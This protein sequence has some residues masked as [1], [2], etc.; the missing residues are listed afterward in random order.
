MNLIYKKIGCIKQRKFYKKK[1]TKQFKVVLFNRIKIFI[2]NVL[3]GCT[4]M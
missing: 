2:F 3:Y 4:H 1:K